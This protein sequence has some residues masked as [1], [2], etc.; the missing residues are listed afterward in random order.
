MICDFDDFAEDQ[1]RLDLLHLLREANPAFRCT[2]FAIPARGTDE[3]WDTVPEWCE[4]AMH[5]WAHPHSREAESWSYEDALD[6]L[7][8]SPARFTEGFKAPGWQIS[9]GT[10]R[11]IIELGWWVADHW[12]NNARRPHGIRAHVISP[13]YRQTEGH[14]HGHIGNVC[15]NGIEETFP[16]L[17]ARVRDAAT[18]E[19]VSE[20][21]TPWA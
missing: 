4:L 7:L 6:V 20:A 5:G 13:D 12:E 19:L 2:L 14:W 1:H 18:F 9:D 16:E 17:L 8:A 11:A 15:G 10:Y 21:V 3:F